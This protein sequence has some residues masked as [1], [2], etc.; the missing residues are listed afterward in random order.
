M[1]VG[2]W[3]GKTMAVAFDFSTANKRWQ[4][5]LKVFSS[6]PHLTGRLL[7]VRRS[8]L[9]VSA[10]SPS[11]LL[12][13]GDKWGP[14]ELPLQARR[15]YYHCLNQEVVA[16]LLRASRVLGEPVLFFRFCLSSAFLGGSE[17]CLPGD[18]GGLGIGQPLPHISWFRFL[19][20][21]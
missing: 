7:P 4:L 12:L 18:P 1:S 5:H 10:F 20:V 19:V 14:K 11:F 16:F 21:S 9:C 6:L 17:H 2:M 8:C 13:W 15:F 3:V